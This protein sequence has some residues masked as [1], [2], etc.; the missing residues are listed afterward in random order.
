VLR[1][2]IDSFNCHNRIMTAE[3]KKTLKYKQY[4]QLKVCFVS[5]EK[6]P[7]SGTGSETIKGAVDIE[8][9]GLSRRFVI[10]YTSSKGDVGEFQ[11][12]GHHTF[13]FSDF[14]LQPPQ[15]MAG[16]IR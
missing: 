5:L 15:K 4:R 2:N 14:Q 11:L 8:L 10:N 3:F 7:F 12:I 1:I 13:C 9:A 6:M 16:L